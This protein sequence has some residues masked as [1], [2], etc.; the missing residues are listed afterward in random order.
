MWWHF[1]RLALSPVLFLQATRVRAATPE[2][3]EPPGPRA[4]VEGEGEIGLRLLVAGDSSAAG[5]GARTQDEAFAQPL[6]RRLAHDLS[7]AV[8]WQLIARTG[9]TSAGLLSELK[10]AA[11]E[12]ADVAVIALGVNDITH[13][14]PLAR[15]LRHRG[16]IASCLRTR[17][18]VRHVIFI[19]LPE[20]DLFPALPDPLAW[21]AGH[22]SRRNN[23]AQARW[24]QTQTGVTHAPMDGVMRPELMAEDGFHPGPALYAR[25]IERL[26]A[27]FARDVLP[28]IRSEENPIP[29]PSPA[30][31]VQRRGEKE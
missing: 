24:A 23:R 11:V 30:V 5:V 13:R 26:S 15:A 2:L 1:V 22:A 16:A 31:N 10:S 9:L 18:G 25:V 29:T 3:P 28:R 21:F 4:G 19:A 6:A 14:V 12:P 8:R 20:M 27:H 7:A 17:A